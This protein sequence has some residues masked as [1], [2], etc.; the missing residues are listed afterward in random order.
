MFW[1]VGGIVQPAVNALGKLQLFAGA[2]GADTYT[3]LMAASLAMGIA[4]GCL[5]AGF[6][7]RGR[8]DGRLVR[9]GAWGTVLLSAL[10]AMPGS[11]NSH[12][13]GFG[14]SI[15][16]L[17]ALGF[18]AGMFAVPVQVYLQSRPPEGKKGRMIATMNLANWI[19][20]LLSAVLYF[21]FGQLLELFDWRPSTMFAF[22]ALL[23]L[24]VALLYRPKSEPLG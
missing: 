9:T 16:A 14:G 23:M 18:F 3:S 19:A 12:L 6:F 17:I 10:L 11:R 5:G 2:K 13:L 1:L 8:V 24:P 20:I 22:T 4:A 21:L 7:S 15:P